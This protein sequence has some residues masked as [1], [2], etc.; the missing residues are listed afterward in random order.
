M[1]TRRTA[2]IVIG[3]IALR[4]TSSK[5]IGDA[6][7]QAGDQAGDQ[8]VRFVKS[9]SE[10][11]TAIVNSNDSPQEKRERI[12]N[13][14]DATVDV[15][16]LGRFCLGRFW[17][18]ATLDQQKQYMALFHDLLVKKVAAHLGEYK[19]VKVGSCSTWDP[20]TVAI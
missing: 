6:W 15:D 5:P 8:A 4:I 1:P 3:A 13:V 12:K 14:I 20:L 9:T 19:G 17:R 18:L 10:R 16:D 11:L 7:A 2:L